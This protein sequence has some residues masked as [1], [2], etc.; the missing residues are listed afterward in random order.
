MAEKTYRVQWPLLIVIVFLVMA[1]LAI[2]VWAK[3][4]K[5]IRSVVINEVTRVEGKIQ[6]PEV[7]Y[8]LPRSNLSFEG[9]KLD[10]K[11]A[12]KIVEAVKKEPF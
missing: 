9:F 11:L 6:K 5:K 8:L 1:L 12:P 2:P 4:K 3:K 7:W 10:K